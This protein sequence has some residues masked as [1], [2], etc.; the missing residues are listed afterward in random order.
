MSSSKRRIAILGSTGSIGRQA[1]SVIEANPER[2]EVVG[3]VAGSDGEALARQAELLGVTAT[4]LG[5]DAAE[6]MAASDNADI[7]LNA[8]VGAA[9]LKASLAALSSGKRL[10]LANKESL[11]AGGEVCLAAARRGGGEIIPIDSEHA[12]LAQCLEGRRADVI[13]RAIL[14]ASGGPFRER[15]DLS[16]VT[17]DEAL[18]HPTWNMGPKITVDSATMMNKG[19]EVIEAHFLFGLG[20]DEIDVLVHPQSIVHALVEL[21]DGS[22][23]MQ[24]APADM[25]IP[26]AAALSAPDRFAP[27]WSTLELA[28][29]PALRFEQVDDSRFPAVALAYEAGRAGGTAT[30]VLNAANEVAVAAFLGGELCFTEITSLSERVLEQHEPEDASELKSVLAADVWARRTAH[31]VITTEPQVVTL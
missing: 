30:A 5:G 14:T 17:Q 11:V 1:I 13:K 15:K 28:S 18:A 7:I 9:G 4:G 25:R 20:Y 21:V 27:A 6:A 12:A 2:F 31:E 23:I 3:L 16:G 22:L 19:L 8:V 29:S 26:I 10:A 24:A